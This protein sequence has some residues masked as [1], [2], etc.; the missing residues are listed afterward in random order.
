VPAGRPTPACFQAGK[1][2][3]ICY[4][5][6]VKEQTVIY[7]E[8]LEVGQE[9]YFGSYEVTREE[10]IDFARKYDPQPFHLSD[11]AAAKTHF[12]RLAA[13]GWHTCAMTMAVIARHV[14]DTEQAG[15]G[16]P[17]I[18]E[19]RW[20]KPVY[21]GDT[22]HVRSTIVEVRPSRS[23]PEIG[24]FRSATTVSNQDGMAVLTFTSI[25]LMRRRPAG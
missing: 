19:L 4:A 17:G 15:L 18:D 12:G 3:S 24:S 21:P 25:V 22:I 16:S 9:T 8:D 6:A 7:F 20:L 10:V 1:P 5:P 23:K 13:S 14:V 11:Q 2:V